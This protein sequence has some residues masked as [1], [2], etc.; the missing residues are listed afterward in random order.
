MVP[1]RGLEPPKAAFVAL[2]AFQSLGANRCDRCGIRIRVL[3]M[4]ARRP[5]QLD[6]S[7]MP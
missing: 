6:E 4:K 3:W 1:R 5:G 2:L 7:V